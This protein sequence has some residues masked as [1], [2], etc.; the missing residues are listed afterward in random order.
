MY[1]HVYDVFYYSQVELILSW[2]LDSGD[3]ESFLFFLVFFIFLS[4]P[5]TWGYILVNVIAGYR[6][7]PAF[8]T[9]V[10]I[11]TVAIGSSCALLV[12]RTLLSSLIR[13]NLM[14]EKLEMIVRVVEGDHGFQVIALTR[15]TPIPF[16]IQ[17]GVFA[18]STVWK[19]NHF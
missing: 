16:G 11:V 4:F 1:L 6:F 10:V 18:V 19:L 15:L 3:A 13:R 14:N 8:G 17:N 9:F 7:G 12:C 5:M 2:L